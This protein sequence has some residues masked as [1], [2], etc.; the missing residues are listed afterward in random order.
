MVSWLVI[1]VGGETVCW[2][3]GHW[4][5]GW[6]KLESGAIGLLVGGLVGQLLVECLVCWIFGEVAR[7]VVGCCV[8][9]LVCRDLHAD[10]CVCFAL[11]ECPWESRAIHDGRP[12]ICVDSTDADAF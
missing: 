7:R 4:F 3:V 1:W 2:L 12:T 6:Q 5:F 9:G 11:H 10:P 8:C